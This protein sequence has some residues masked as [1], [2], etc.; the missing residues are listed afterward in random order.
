MTTITTQDG[1]V[2]DR[3]ALFMQREARPYAEHDVAFEFSA[4]G[5]VVTLAEAFRTTGAHERPRIGSWVEL[6]PNYI[7]GRGL[8]GWHWTYS[9]PTQAAAVAAMLS[10][11]QVGPWTAKETRRPRR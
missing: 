9:Y 11:G 3:V 7:V 5:R 8:A 10:R 2:A 6:W 1:V 4:V